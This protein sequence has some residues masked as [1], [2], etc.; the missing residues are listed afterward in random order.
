MVSAIRQLD[1]SSILAIHLLST[2]KTTEYFVNLD[3]NPHCFWLMGNSSYQNIH[4][5]IVHIPISRYKK[6]RTNRM[7]QQL[8]HGR[9]KCISC[10][11]DLH[12]LISCSRFVSGKP[13]LGVRGGFI[14]FFWIM[15]HSLRTRFI[16][17]LLSLLQWLNVDAFK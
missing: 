12:K 4:H 8:K 7:H 10:N 13:Q 5:A 16:F 3:K 11:L 15:S 17:E 9:K 6:N 14:A 1:H 2:D